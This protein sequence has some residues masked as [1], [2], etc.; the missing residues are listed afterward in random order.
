MRYFST[1]EM[2]NIVVCN[3]SKSDFEV[4]TFFDYFL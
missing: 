1:F 2:I 4:I 3:L